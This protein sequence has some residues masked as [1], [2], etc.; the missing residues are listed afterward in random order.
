MSFG[1][2]NAAEAVIFAEEGFR[3]HVQVMVQTRLNELGITQRELA[4]RLGV[5][6]ERASQLL[7]NEARLT[8]R[9]VGRIFHAL[10]CEPR[11]TFGPDVERERLATALEDHT[12]EQ[13][14]LVRLAIDDDES[15]DDEECGRIKGLEEAVAF[16]RE[17][18]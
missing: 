9:T 3:V 6:D 10:G 4:K 8:V 13:R 5:S 12:E 7:S 15:A 2:K 11:L 1:P 14:A 16:I 18:A 17:R